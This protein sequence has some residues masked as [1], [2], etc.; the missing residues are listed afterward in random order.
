MVFIFVSFQL[1]Q[2]LRVTIADY[3]TAF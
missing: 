2:N 1:D 3:S